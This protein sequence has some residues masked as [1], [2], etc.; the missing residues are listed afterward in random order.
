MPF[1]S[2]S[3]SSAKDQQEKKDLPGDRT[4]SHISTKHEYKK[5]ASV[6]HLG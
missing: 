2:L 1:F 5:K 4:S 6:V 3:L